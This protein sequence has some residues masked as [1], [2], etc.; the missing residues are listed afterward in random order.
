MSDPAAE[1]DGPWKEALETYFRLFLEFLFPLIACDVDWEHVIEFLDTELQKIAPEAD[2]GRGSVDKLVRVWTK[3]GTQE[4]MLIHIEV[5]SQKDLE[6]PHRMYRYNHRLEDRYGKMPVSIAVL[7]DED[8]WWS[9]EE[10]QRGRWGCS[11]K[12]VFPIAKLMDYFGREVELEEHS[13]PFASFVLA[14]MKTNQTQGNPDARLNWKLRI[15]KRLY[16][17]GMS[18]TEIRKLFRLV[19]WVMALPPPQAAAFSRDLEA[20]EKEKEVPFITSTEQV[21]LEEGRAKGRIEGIE[22]ILDVRFGAAGVALIP[23]IRQI[24]DAAVLE[25]LLRES[26]SVSDLAT[27]TAMLPAQPPQT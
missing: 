2:A 27:F 24:T 3:I 11:V 1:F 19:D 4:E 23:R 20:F 6:F 18:G 10:F 22:A 15:A 8:R 16:D 25:R 17:R 12:F 9:P 7:G 13:N 21:W 14:H 5:Q 26:K